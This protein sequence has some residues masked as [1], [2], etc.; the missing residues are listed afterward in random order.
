[1]ANQVTTTFKINAQAALT[2][3]KQYADQLAQTIKLQEQLGKTVGGARG[4]GGVAGGGAAGGGGALFG[5]VSRLGGAIFGGLSIAAVTSFAKVAIEA[6]ND[7]TRANRALASSAVEA[8][9]SYGELSRAAREFGEA[10]GISSAQAARSTAQLQRLVSLAGEGDQ[11]ERYQ[12]GFLDLA[13]AR[14]VAFEELD[15]LFSGIIAG[16]DDALNRFGKQDPSK[17]AAIYAQQLGKSVEQ[18]TEQEKVLSRLKAFEPDFGLFSG[19]NEARVKSFDG[20]ID[21]FNANISNTVANIGNWIS[22]SELLGDVLSSLNRTIGGGSTPDEIRTRIGEGEDPASILAD[23]E[24]RLQEENGQ[25]SRLMTAL[26]GGFV[27]TYENER[28][29]AQ[30]IERVKAQIDGAVKE[31]DATAQ[32]S[33]A[34]LSKLRRDALLADLKFQVVETQRAYDLQ[35]NV[36]LAS[37]SVF[38][39]ERRSLLDGTKT[40][41]L[42]FDR[43][44]TAARIQSLR[45]ETQL[46]NALFSAQMRQ[47]SLEGRDEEFNRLRFEQSVFARQQALAIQLEILNARE[48]ERQKVEQ[49]NKEI[50]RITKDLRNQ[51]L[52]FSGEQNPYVRLFGEAQNAV[53]DLIEKTKEFGQEFRD[54]VASGIGQR[55]NFQLLTQDISNFRQAVGLR[56]QASELRFGIDPSAFNEEERL[57]YRRESIYEDLQAIEQAFRRNRGVDRQEAERARDRAIIEATQGATAREFY[58]DDRFTAAEAREREA[59]RLERDRAQSRQV[60]DSLIQEFAQ[61]GIR[62]R[63]ADGESTVRI[64]DETSGSVDIATRPSRNSTNQRY[65]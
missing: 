47:A 55:L 23:F 44:I 64:I 22:R 33:E 60:F 35:K 5:G 40:K 59:V 29:I 39:A 25:G 46:R 36:G 43:E 41:E 8:G 49:I 15:T 37:L 30:F 50:D 51:L 53:E 4:G 57:A 31:R 63:I 52:G 42:Q 9:R 61:G 54:S 10:A 24:R 17:L 32:Q 7:A 6:T 38:E 20:Q 1:M 58:L 18:L 19:A 45:Q 14:G 27:F 48:K 13:A 56:R 21:K 65:R 26:F 12:Q 62:V 16:T 2:A 11:L 3:L 34:N 28:A